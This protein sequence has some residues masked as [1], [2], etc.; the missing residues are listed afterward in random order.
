MPGADYNNAPTAHQPVI[1][2]SRE[3][4]DRELILA[5]WGPVLFLTKDLKEIKGLS[6]INA[7]AETFA[8][9]RTLREPTRERASHQDSRRLFSCRAEVCSPSPVSGMR[10]RTERV[11]GYSRTPS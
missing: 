6:T 7:R 1:R 8:S 3:T 9:S 5:R 10:G 2:Q 11:A 4:G